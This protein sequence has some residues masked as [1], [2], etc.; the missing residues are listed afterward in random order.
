MITEN[1]RGL[2]RALAGEETDLT[3]ITN[4]LDGIDAVSDGAEARISELEKKLT[5][6]EDRY[7]QTAA[8]NYEL[9]LS[10]TGDAGEGDS[11]AS[12]DDGEDEPDDS[13]I[14]DSLFKED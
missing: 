7:T 14:I 6:A 1:L 11:G 9:M 13:A 4:E 5:D 12:D 3:D 2:I 10:A 8:K